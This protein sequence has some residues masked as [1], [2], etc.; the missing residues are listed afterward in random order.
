[1]SSGVR[2]KQEPPDLLQIDTGDSDGQN[3]DHNQT[4]STEAPTP[5]QPQWDLKT[6]FPW[7]EP[8]EG[9]SLAICCLCK[10][11]GQENALICDL[12]VETLVSHA[13]GAD[14]QHAERI[15]NTEMFESV[16]D[17]ATGIDAMIRHGQILGAQRDLGNVIWN[18]GESSPS[19]KY[20]RKFCDHWFQMFP[21][22][23]FDRDIGM[24][25]CQVCLDHSE[26]RH[27]SFVK[28]NNSF[29]KH[30]LQA[31]EGCEVHQRAMKKA[32]IYF[33]PST[34]IGGKY[35]RSYD[36]PE[37]TDSPE[38]FENTV[39]DSTD[40]SVRERMEREKSITLQRIE[41]ENECDKHLDQNDSM[42]DHDDP[43]GES[44]ISP[45]KKR[46]RF[47]R[48][49]LVQFP[50]LK[51]DRDKG[52]LFCKICIKHNPTGSSSF[53]KG[54]NN[55][56]LTTI[57]SHAFCREHQLAERADA[58]NKAFSAAEQ[59]GVSN[60]KLM[61]PKQH[62]M[63][64]KFLK[65]FPWLLHNTELNVVVCD[66]CQRH[67]TNSLYIDCTSELEYDIVRTHAESTR[68]MKCEQLEVDTW[69]AMW[70]TAS[71]ENRDFSLEDGLS[72]FAL[73]M[74]SNAYNHS[75][76][77]SSSTPQL[78][79]MKEE[80]D[81]NDNVKQSSAKIS[82]LTNLNTSDS[83]DEDDAEDIKETPQ[84]G[85]SANVP[86]LF[87]ISE[88]SSD[89]S[90]HITNDVAFSS[91]ELDT[92]NPWS[93]YSAAL[94]GLPTASFPSANIHPALLAVD[95]PPRRKG[96]YKPKKS[97]ILPAFGTFKI[98]WLAEFPWLTYDPISDIM[99]CI[100]CAKYN[101][102][103][104]FARGVRIFSKSGLVHHTKIAKHRDSLRK[105]GL[106]IVEY[107]DP[108][109]RQRRVPRS[110][111]EEAMDIAGLNESMDNQTDLSLHGSDDHMTGD[112]VAEDTGVMQE[113]DEG[114][115][116]SH[117]HNGER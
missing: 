113:D 61:T 35:S 90:P 104:T 68:H 74:V 54:N 111:S 108:I 55:M 109:P 60:K 49:W 10:K 15:C 78:N 95:D 43:S 103:T 45:D 97:N 27:I 98:K 4:G 88:T 57:Q 83:L 41:E 84:K 56:R 59:D 92:S 65:F 99:K 77:E 1:M 117:E 116:S 23:L 93:A 51:Y 32:G 79:D 67:G 14:H 13:W 100:Y 33:P 21:W 89:I 38:I 58:F 80:K 72:S 76:E 11:T 7:L 39:N 101:K 19:D 105:E 48:H 42:G 29:K 44:Y 110:T 31:H 53:I 20:R 25:Y 62:F 37:L 75:E 64:Q 16:K 114:N 63:L 24:M 40:L 73:P 2:V 5:Q 50:W 26:D 81:K 8:G 30:T 46:R 70:D 107:P 85:P 69:S 22:L 96:K 91:G 3:C 87:K 94:A 17:E 115:N 112:E 9:A 47:C 86:I 12:K 106:P 66:V 82:E 71:V 6:H 36:S 102:C 18:Q 28:G 34:G 52:L